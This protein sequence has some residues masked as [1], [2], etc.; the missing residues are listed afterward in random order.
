MNELVKLIKQLIKY[1][2]V[3]Y[4]ILILILVLMLYI[5]N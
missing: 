1:L 4:L 2:Y 5:N 3:G